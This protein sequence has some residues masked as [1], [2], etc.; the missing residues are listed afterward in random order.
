MLSRDHNAFIY[1]SNSDRNDIVE[2]IVYSSVQ[3]LNTSNTHCLSPFISWK[4][5]GVS[6]LP[7]LYLSTWS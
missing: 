3:L 4:L 1:A 6:K 7:L 2:I 5:N